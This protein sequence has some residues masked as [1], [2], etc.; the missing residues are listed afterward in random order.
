MDRK[1]NWVAI[2]DPPPPRQYTWKP[3]GEAKRRQYTWIPIGDRVENEVK[4]EVE[5]DEEN[6][7]AK[8]NETRK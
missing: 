3:I 7:E 8:A 5:N 2:G 1:V 4:Q 6:K